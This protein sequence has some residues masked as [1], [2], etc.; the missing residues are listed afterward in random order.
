MSK[1]NEEI[2][3]RGRI[4]DLA[5]ETHRMPDDR[6]ACFEIVQHPGGS[7][8]LP[9]LADGRVILIRQFR[10]AAASYVLEIPAGR[11]ETGE[12]ADE[13]IKRELQ[14]EIGYS[15]EKVEDLGYVYSSMGFCTEKIHLFIATG[16][17]KTETALEPD[18]FI[19][20]IVM[21]IE[22]ALEKIEDGS[23]VDAKT[24]LALMRYALKSKG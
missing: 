14:E 23:I 10:P 4:L 20:P 5:R 2:I 12:N 13:C 7:A 16:L 17:H 19:E 6:E 8:A 21:T 3:Y 9:V 1:T 15:A 11:L 22:K 24:Q 18:E